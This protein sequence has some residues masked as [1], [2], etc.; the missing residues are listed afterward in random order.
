MNKKFWLVSVS[1]LDDSIGLDG[2]ELKV[3]DSSVS[4]IIVQAQKVLIKKKMQHFF[5]LS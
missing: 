3:I 2:L 5:F 4:P 1:A